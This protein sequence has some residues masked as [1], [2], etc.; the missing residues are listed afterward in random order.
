MEGSK[1]A[2]LHSSAL[3]P[4][5][6]RQE[7]GT[8]DR[9]DC[10]DNLFERFRLQ[11]ADFSDHPWPGIARKYVAN[12]SRSYHRLRRWLDDLHMDCW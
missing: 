3:L 4:L 11:R 9:Y 10:L 2:F 8:K 7:A 12:Q 1:L 6:L 5:C